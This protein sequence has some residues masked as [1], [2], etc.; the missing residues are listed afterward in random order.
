MPESGRG[1]QY[2]ASSP[3][4]SASGSGVVKT[5]SWAFWKPQTEYLQ[6]DQV[7]SPSCRTAVAHCNAKPRLVGTTS[8]P[9]VRIFLFRGSGVVP[10]SFTSPSMRLRVRKR[11]RPMG[12]G[13]R[14]S[15]RG[16]SS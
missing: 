12:S 9:S 3:F 15:G 4:L 16:L 7:S 5:Y 2:G 6:V 1:H 13:G 11:R 8:P 14:C 10:S